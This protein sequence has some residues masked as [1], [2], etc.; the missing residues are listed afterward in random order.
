M[1]DEY[2]ELQLNKRFEHQA[3]FKNK[4]KKVTQKITKFLKNLIV[5]SIKKGKS[6]KS[7]HIYSTM[8]MK[9][10]ANKITN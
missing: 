9:N 3:E 6:G 10:E 1:L 5:P 2:D 7:M 8:K 4:S